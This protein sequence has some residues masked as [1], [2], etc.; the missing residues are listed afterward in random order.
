MP[1][2]PS[3]NTESSTFTS[4][5]L[6]T[7]W[8]SSTAASTL[9]FTVSLTRISA[10][11]FKLCSSSACVRRTASGGR[12]TRTGFRGTPC[13]PPI[14]HKPLW[15]P[16]LSTAWTGTR[17]PSGLTTSL[18][19]TWSWRTWRSRPAAAGVWRQCLSDETQEGVRSFTTPHH[20]SWSRALG[21]HYCVKNRVLW[22]IYD[23]TSLPTN[24]HL[25][26]N[27]FSHHPFL[28]NKRDVMYVAPSFH[29]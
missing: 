5:P 27:P 9:L 24:A 18:S 7:G 16:S 26:D 10:E 15:S 14:T 8:P 6:P 25:S 29:V 20:P 21:L 22:K 3:S 1:G 23:S 28:Q 2:W 4:T 11:D 17:P 12:P 19:R 13:C